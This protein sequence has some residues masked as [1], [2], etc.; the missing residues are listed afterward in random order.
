MEDE[1]DMRLDLFFYLSL[2][3]AIVL[4]TH[5]YW[6]RIQIDFLSLTGLCSF[7]YLRRVYCLKGVIR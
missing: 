3:S 2:S 5:N 6:A 7:P 1:G 4:N